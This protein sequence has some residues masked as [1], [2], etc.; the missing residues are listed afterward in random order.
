MSCFQLVNSLIYCITT[1]HEFSANL[2]SIKETVQVPKLYKPVIFLSLKLPSEALQQD[3]QGL[4]A[5]KAPQKEACIE[6]FILR[7]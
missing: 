3:W 5:F 6:K 2:L 1:R 7:T 4:L